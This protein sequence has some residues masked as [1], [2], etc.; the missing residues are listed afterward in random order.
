MEF[1]VGDKV[2]VKVVDPEQKGQSKAQAVVTHSHTRTSDHSLDA[3]PVPL[4]PHYC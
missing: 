2:E 1:K 3:I 4:S